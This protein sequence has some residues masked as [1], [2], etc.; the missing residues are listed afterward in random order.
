MLKKFHYRSVEQ[1]KLKLRELERKSRSR[2]LPSTSNNTDVKRHCAKNRDS[3]VTTNVQRSVSN[4]QAQIDQ[5]K[6]M[7]EKLEKTNKNKQNESYP[8]LLSEFTHKSKR[9]KNI[10]KRKKRI[11]N[12]I[13]AEK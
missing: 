1:N 5:L 9:G 2:N 7:M 6:Q 12:A 13:R 4:I 3:N 11:R 10:E 8:C